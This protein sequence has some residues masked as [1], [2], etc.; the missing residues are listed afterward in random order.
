MSMSLPPSLGYRAEPTRVVDVP[1]GG[2]RQ[3]EQCA[4][5]VV[6]HL[7]QVSSSMGNHPY[8]ADRHTVSASD[9]SYLKGRI[10]LFY[11]HL[12]VRGLYP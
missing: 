7:H 8:V 6:L 10:A 4:M 11:F 2:P 9:Y 5:K 3:I 1:E 12:V